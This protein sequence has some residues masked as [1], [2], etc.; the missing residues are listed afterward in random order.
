MRIVPKSTSNNDLAKVL[1][2]AIGKWMPEE[3]QPVYTEYQELHK[4]PGRSGDEQEASKAAGKCLENLKQA[5]G[6]DEQ[7]FIKYNIG[8]EEVKF[9]E[10]VEFKQPAFGQVPSVF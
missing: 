2:D 3:W 8:G 9:G 7:F 1:Y 6:I 10:Q 5:N 4:H